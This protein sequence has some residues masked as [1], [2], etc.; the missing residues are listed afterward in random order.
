MLKFADVQ[1]VKVFFNFKK[2][3]SFNLSLIKPR[4]VAESHSAV[5]G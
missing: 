4:R 2:V 3:Y 5:V 1:D